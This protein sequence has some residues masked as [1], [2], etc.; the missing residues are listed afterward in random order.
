MLNTPYANTVPL[1]EQ[2]EMLNRAAM[3]FC[4]A[5]A[6]HPGCEMTWPMRQAGMYMAPFRLAHRPKNWI[7]PDYGAVLTPDNIDGPCGAQIAGGI[8]RWMAVPWQTDT[9]SC[10]SGYQKSYDPY[11]PTFWPARVP[12]Q[13]MSQRAY[14]TV[15]D[16]SLPIDD[17]LSAFAKRAA[18][19]RP[20]GNISYQ[21]QINN[22]IK[23]IAQMGIVEVREGPK[24]SAGFPSFLEVEQLPPPSGEKRLLGAVIVAEEFEDVD[25][26]TVEKARHLGS[27]RRN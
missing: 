25:L 6:F 27:R 12:N 17:R 10:R 1:A 3:E 26:T 9:A 16:E 22:M 21:D 24:D 20:L 8:T 13:V 15:I 18:W 2:P 7:E 5:D 11:L 19:I 23:D 14:E 4:L